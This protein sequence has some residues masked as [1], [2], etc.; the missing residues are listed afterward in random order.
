M[1][2]KITL[3]KL[4]SL[5][6][7]MSALLSLND[8]F[9]DLAN[10][11]DTLVSRD[12][13]VPNHML[14]DLD[15]NNHDLLNVSLLEVDY[16]TVGGDDVLASY[17][18]KSETDS[19]LNARAPLSH[20]HSF[21]TDIHSFPSNISELNFSDFVMETLDNV[22]V[23]SPADADV[24]IWDSTLYGGTGG[25]KNAPQS[26]SGGGIADAPAGAYHVR[27]LGSWK[28]PVLDDLGD[29]DTTS[30][31][32]VSG[33]LLRF[34]GTHFVP[35]SNYLSKTG[36]SDGKQYVLVDD[37][38][39]L[40]TLN[41]YNANALG[42]VNYDVAP[43]AGQVLLYE[44]GEWRPRDVPPAADPSDTTAGKVWGRGYNG[45]WGWVEA[46]PRNTNIQSHIIQTNNP[47][48]TKLSNLTFD[49]TGSIHELTG[50]IRPNTNGILYLGTST[51]QFSDVYSV[52]GHFS[53]ITTDEIHSSGSSISIDTSVL[54]SVNTVSCGDQTNEFGIGGFR[55]IYTNS[56]SPVDSSEITVSAP[57]RPFPNNSVACGTNSNRWSA[58]WST[59]V[60]TGLLG[61]LDNND[62]GI[63]NDIV[64]L[65]GGYVI[66]L[67]S[68]ANP[69]IDVHCT[70][71]NTD[72]VVFSGADNSWQ[73]VTFENGW[74]E[75]SA[76]F[77]V[78][79]R[80]LDDHTIEIRG[81]LKPGTYA[82][83]A[84]TLPVGYRPA[85]SLIFASQ[86][87]LQNKTS[88][89]R[90]G[91]DGTVKIQFDASSTYYTVTCTFSTKA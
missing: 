75:F 20:T 7:E 4:N 1:A 17:Y 55:Q 65:P 60:I 43:V 79:Y 85:S 10:K 72:S 3:R 47:H 31:S 42:D 83:T 91:S 49:Y 24:L 78:R 53:A 59:Q 86:G 71:L 66:N 19:L 68:S 63:V 82:A 34:D 51:R 15:M 27:T 58:T 13:D 77:P 35:F 28:V 48:A 81:L 36:I 70:T 52:A 37:T 69:F 56:I 5:T 18:T 67:G 21:T 8:N 62:I 57:L 25:W 33:D 12:G 45:S 9:N 54:P 6:N 88:Q 64:P 30:V 16:L 23:T 38:F 74:S 39:T 87:D 46:E 90:I 32:P 22:T 44:G 61:G 29:V 2:D 41:P 84:F 89:L 73:T 26:G 11:I 40:F 50:N 80:K 14:S 76:S